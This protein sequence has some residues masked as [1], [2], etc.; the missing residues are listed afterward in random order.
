MKYIFRIFLLVLS[1]NLIVPSVYGNDNEESKQV[2]VSCNSGDYGENTKNNPKGRR[3]PGC[4][5]CLIDYVTLEISLS[6]GEE[7]EVYQIWTPDESICILSTADQ[8]EFVQ[9]LKQMSEA[10]F[11]LHTETSGYH[12]CLCN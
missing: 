6:N 12:G 11:V 5:F 2:Q 4:V 9:Q 7:I 3:V 8:V 1:I 10:V